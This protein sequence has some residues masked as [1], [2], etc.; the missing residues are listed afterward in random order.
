MKGGKIAALKKRKASA[1]SELA[2]SVFAGKRIVLNQR[3]PPFSIRVINTLYAGRKRE[4]GTHWIVIA[5]WHTHSQERQKDYLEDISHERAAQLI[6]RWWKRLK[7][8]ETDE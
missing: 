3:Y 8:V 6:E 4:V 2:L 1:L 5:R 7:N